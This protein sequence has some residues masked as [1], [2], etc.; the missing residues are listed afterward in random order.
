[1]A[2]GWSNCDMKN[3]LIPPPGLAA[4]RHWRYSV[5]F[6]S[7]ELRAFLAGF[8]PPF[9]PALFVRAERYAGDGPQ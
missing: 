4:P 2:R 6:D 9:E 3:Q 1:M 7:L 5:A 8:V